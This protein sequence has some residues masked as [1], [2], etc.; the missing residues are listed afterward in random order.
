M[1]TT[2]LAH[3]TRASFYVAQKNDG[4][5]PRHNQDVAPDRPNHTGVTATAA[6]TKL[7]NATENGKHKTL[8]PAGTPAHREPA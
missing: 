1:R 6:A 8:L 5:I 2:C 7:H 4:P 3:R